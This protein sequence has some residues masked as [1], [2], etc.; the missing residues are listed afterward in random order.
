[1]RQ[2]LRMLVLAGS[3]VG[4]GQSGIAASNAER[5]HSLDRLDPDGGAEWI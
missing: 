2:N 3:G 4:A 5:L 1:M